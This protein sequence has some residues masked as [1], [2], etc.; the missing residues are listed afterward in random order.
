MAALNKKML[1]YLFLIYG[2]HHTHLTHQH[3]HTYWDFLPT[4]FKLHFCDLFRDVLIHIIYLKDF[5]F[6][7]SM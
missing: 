5:T 6:S 1:L 4:L 7:V 2:K 3:H